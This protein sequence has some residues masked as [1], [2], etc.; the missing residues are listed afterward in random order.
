MISKTVTMQLESDLVDR[1]IA[2][3][4]QAASRFESSIYIETG[5]KK[6]NAKSI[7]GMM[8]MKLNSEEQV[9]IIA[10]GPDEQQALES[11]ENFLTGNRK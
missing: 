11:M 3:L 2:L 10:T 5:Y 7:M 4:V 9:T 8:T 1:P 6:I